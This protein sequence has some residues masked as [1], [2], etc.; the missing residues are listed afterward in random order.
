M[1]RKAERERSTRRFTVPKGARFVV[2]EATKRGREGKSLALPG[3]VDHA[4]ALSQG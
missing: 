2:G 4:A 3:G 1:S